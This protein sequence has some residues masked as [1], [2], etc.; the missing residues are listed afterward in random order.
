M[1]WQPPQLHR[2]PA[3]VFRGPESC[4][5][6]DVYEGSFIFNPIKLAVFNPRLQ[7]PKF[8]I[9]ASS[10]RSGCSPT[11]LR[12]IFSAWDSPTFH[13][14]PLA[15]IFFTITHWCEANVAHCSSMDAKEALALYSNIDAWSVEV[16]ELKICVVKSPYHPR[17][18]LNVQD[19]QPRCF[20]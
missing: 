1:Q 7:A 10:I 9:N 19:F 12:E 8:L 11:S 6:V 2:D 14:Q 5:K 20:T 3:S 16:I 17:G 13:P 18:S 15:P 4:L